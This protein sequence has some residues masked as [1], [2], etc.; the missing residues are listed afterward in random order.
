[1]HLSNKGSRFL[2][3]A[4]IKSKVGKLRRAAATVELVVCLPVLLTVTFCFI[5]A[6]NFLHLQQKLSAIAFETVRSASEK[7]ATFA[8][9]KAFGEKIGNSRD[10]AG[11]VIQ[12]EPVSSSASERSEMDAGELVQARAYAPAEGNMAGP[13]VLFHGA[14]ASSPVVVV[15]VQ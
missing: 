10:V 12:L 14:E 5:D 6:C 8:T 11:L 1:M 2:V 15:A 7:E 3:K 4:M 13:F 9:A